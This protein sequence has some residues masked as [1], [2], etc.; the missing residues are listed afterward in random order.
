[1][2]APK[3]PAYVAGK[4]AL[5]WCDYCDVWHVHGLPAEGHRVA[6]CDR[7]DSAYKATGYY[8]DLQPLTPEIERKITQARR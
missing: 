1:M 7:D 3:L 2:Q 4:Q 5:V 8:L 6:H